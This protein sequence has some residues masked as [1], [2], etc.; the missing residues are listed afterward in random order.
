MRR[1]YFDID[2]GTFIRDEVGRAMEGDDILKAEA[3]Q[4]AAELMKA[5]AKEAKETAI[6]LSVRDETGEQKL[7]I[8]VVCQVE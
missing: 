8:R 2:D 3:L 5:E 6:Q 4:V 7:V 1:Y